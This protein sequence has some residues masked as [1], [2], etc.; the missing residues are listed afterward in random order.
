MEMLEQLL[1]RIVSRVNV[2]LRE[3]N[4]NITDHVRH[5]I[6]AN[7]FLQFHAFYGL[8]PYKKLHFY[9]KSSNLAGSSLLGKCTVHSSVLYKSHLR[10]DELKNQGETLPYIGFQIPVYE[11]EV[12]R[13]KDSFLIKNLI[14]SH[15]HD[16]ENPDEFLI[17]NTVSMHY[18]N[19]HGSTVIGCFLAPFS[20]VDMSTFR[21]CVIGTFSYVQA[22]R[23][24]HQLVEPGRIWIKDGE[25]FE[26]DYRFPAGVVDRYI[27]LEPGS[28]PKGIFIDFVEQREEDWEPILEMARYE[29]PVADVA[30]TAAFSRYAVAKGTTSVL[31]NVYVAQGAYLEDAYMG[32]GSNAQENCYIIKSRLDG[33]VVTAHGGKVIHCRLGSHVFVGFNSFLNG[34]ENCPIKVGEESIVMP[35]T[36]IDADEPLDIPPRH[37]VWGFIGNRR[38]LEQNSVNLNDLSM[39]STELQKGNLSFK[40][41]GHA[42]VRAFKHR[43]EHILELNGAF[44]DGMS[45]PGHIHRI[46][47]ASFNTIQPYYGGPLK[48]L[49]ADMDIHPLDDV[50]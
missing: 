8:T 30:A 14:H 40:G 27:S 29:P 43:I 46:R 48:G 21:N 28:P 7:K 35:H 24:T 4:Y 16:P 34:K 23:L 45:K 3:L 47:D 15:S 50:V 42:F 41:N 9:I 36:I 2:C 38:D 33:N 18:A 32:K 17:K 49:F 37:L 19:I 1:D 5:V 31:E 11:D 26:F 13:I 25:S 22:R 6:P 20:T 44:F 10:G 39:I 12:V